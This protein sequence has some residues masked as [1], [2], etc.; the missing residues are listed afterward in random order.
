VTVVDNLGRVVLARTLAA[1]AT[2]TLELPLASLAPGVYAV[3]AR[4]AQG[5][6]AQRLVVE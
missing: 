3:L 6:V 4:T 5:L 1:G 2:E